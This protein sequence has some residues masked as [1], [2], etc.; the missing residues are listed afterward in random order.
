MQIDKNP[1]LMCAQ[2]PY[3]IADWI[4]GINPWKHLQPSN[5]WHEGGW[6][7]RQFLFESGNTMGEGLC[8]HKPFDLSN[9]LLLCVL[10]RLQRNGLVQLSANARPPNITKL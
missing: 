7:R 5:Q 10:N 6:P 2:E 1:N 8:P 3:T 4:K 9:A